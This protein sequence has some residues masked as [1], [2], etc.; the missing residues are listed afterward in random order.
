MNFKKKV[1]HVKDSLVQDIKT[2]DT[3]RE[4]LENKVADD[5]DKLGKNETYIK[6]KNE[7][8]DKLVAM[9]IQ[10]GVSIASAQTGSPIIVEQK[11]MDNIADKGGDV[12]VS[13]WDKFI[14]FLK[15]QL[16]K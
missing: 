4:E 5:M 16:R 12:V 9:G 11:T 2:I 15:W 3:Q 6:L 1:K 14:S 10:L 13:L 7:G 8:A